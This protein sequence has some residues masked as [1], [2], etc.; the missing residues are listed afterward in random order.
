MKVYRDYIEEIF[1][2]SSAHINIVIGKDFYFETVIL[3]R[4]Q[5]TEQPIITAKGLNMAN[6][7]IAG[8]K[9]PNSLAYHPRMSSPRVIPTLAAVGLG[10]GP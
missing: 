7:L 1:L 5:H 3:N 6:T 4:I 8:R 2:V 9:T 10:R